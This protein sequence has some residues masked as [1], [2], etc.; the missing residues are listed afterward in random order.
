MNSICEFI[1]FQ[2]TATA[3]VNQQQ[4]SDA[5]HMAY[6]LDE[7]IDGWV[8]RR[9]GKGRLYYFNT[10]TRP[11]QWEFPIHWQVAWH[12]TEEATQP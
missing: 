11:S 2:I 8:L 5:K 7:L 4:L 12:K 10:E 6:F 3:Q 9:S 1:N